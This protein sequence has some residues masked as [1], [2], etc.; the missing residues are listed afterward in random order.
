MLC[1]CQIVRG[2]LDLDFLESSSELERPLGVACHLR[3]APRVHP[4]V[5]VPI[6]GTPLS[7]GATGTQDG[8]VG[9][10]N[11]GASWKVVNVQ[12]AANLGQ[13]FGC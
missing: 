8:R 2:K 10:V 6:P 11:V 7:V 1:L 12:A 3:I 4:T 5:S 13:R 9:S